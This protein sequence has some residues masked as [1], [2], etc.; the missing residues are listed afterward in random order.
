M[1]VKRILVLGL[2]LLCI[3]FRANAQGISNPIATEVSQLLLEQKYNKVHKLFSGKI[4]LFFSR[5][6]FKKMW[7][8][9]EKGNGKLQSTGKVTTEQK[10][11]LLISTI[12]LNFEKLGLNLLLTTSSKGK[13]VGLNF[14]PLAYELPDW[15]KNKVY[16]KERLV[17]ETDSFKLSGELILPSDCR[18]C[19][20]VIIVHGSGPSDMDGSFGP[21]KFYL[22]LAYG[23][24]NNGIATIRY[25]KR[26]FTYGKA[27]SKLDSITLY[28]ET[29]E[30]AISAV[31]L[32]KNYSFLDSTN[33]FVLGHSLGAYASPLI[34]LG[35]P[36]VDGII[37]LGGPAR[38][39]YKI[40]PE[41]YEYLFNLDS[42]LSKKESAK[43]DRVKEEVKLVEGLPSE[44]TE[45]KELGTSDM[46]WYH[47]FMLTYDPIQTIDSIK[48]RTLI[49]QGDRDYQVR[50]QT[51]FRAYQI[52][53]KHNL[54]VDFKLI[55]GANHLMVFGEK[56][57][58]PAEYFKQDHIDLSTLEYL[59]NWIKEK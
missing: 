54:L 4:K 21:N 9:L 45:L 5:K 47:R 57:S 58:E 6:K 24:A 30:D 50:H 7:A 59:S 53:L 3:G 43:M 55:K 33:I 34:A 29:I 2:L 42:S 26:S 44:V 40:I 15:A 19:P 41:Q 1:R 52:G 11:D 22:D 39:V 36:E 35:E 13:I 10:D 20:V 16:G 17:V 46:L 31:R 48:R 49:I 56:P 38:P 8:G 51:E 23:L 32:V 37:V 18:N 28:E 12:P 25:N 27:M 14:L